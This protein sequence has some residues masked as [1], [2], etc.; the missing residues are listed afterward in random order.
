MYC[1]SCGTETAAGAV[2]CARCGESLGTADAGRFRPSNAV[3]VAATVVAAGSMALAAWTTLHLRPAAAPVNRI[4]TPLPRLMTTPQPS[5]TAV[6]SP[7]PSPAPAESVARGRYFS[8][9]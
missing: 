6:P 2:N 9:A 5:P 1:P 3:L 4:Q 7:S 8:E